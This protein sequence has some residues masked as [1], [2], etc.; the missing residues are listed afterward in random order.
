MKS[1]ELLPA[2]E[3]LL[4][5]R[6]AE[7]AWTA[8]ARQ[9]LRRGFPHQLYVAYRVLRGMGE[10]VI[11]DGVELSSLPYPLARE[12]VN[13]KLMDHVP[14]RRWIVRNQGAQSF[15][16]AR[17]RRL[18]GRLTASEAL[19]LEIFE[20]FGHGA[21][22]AL[23]L[24]D[25]APRLRGGILFLAGVGASQEM[26]DARWSHAGRELELLANLLHQRLAQL[27]YRRAEE[28]L[29]IRQREALEL[30]GLGLSTQDIAERMKVSVATVEKHL[31]LARKALGAKTT[32]HAVLIACS[33]GVIFVD[34]G[35][36]CSMQ[37]PD[38][39]L[40]QIDTPWNFVSFEQ[41]GQPAGNA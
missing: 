15:D 32:T 31:R 30:T 25:R 1:R 2:V 3:E 28:V 37:P 14:M 40:G 38:P 19:A 5:A 18:A 27:P 16:W 34:P 39:D 10:H 22:M 24:A 23:S 11:L 17:R 9:A 4:G 7:D 13:R 36:A 33:R 26:V 6:K 35:E 20:Q 29:T 12:I 21:G 8:F 41:P